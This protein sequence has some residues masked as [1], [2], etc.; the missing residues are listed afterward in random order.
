VDRQQAARTAIITTAGVVGTAVGAAGLLAAQVGHAKR[1][2][3]VRHTSPPYSDARYGSSKGSSIRLV[4]I[5]D[6]VA[7]SLGAEDPRDTI[8]A[9]LATLVSEYDGR[10]VV[11]STV[12]EVGARSRDLDAQID[13]AL[14]YRPHVAVVIIGGNDI[15]HLTPQWQAIKSLDA[16]IRRLRSQ[17][18]QVVVGTVPDLGI[19][20]PFPLPLRWV[21]RQLGRS[22]A[23][24]QTVCVVQAG[25][26]AVSMGDTLGPEFDARPEDMFANDRF[27]PSAEGYEAVAQVIA[28]S[29]IAGLSRGE[30][31]EVLPDIFQSPAWAPLRQIAARAAELPGMEITSESVVDKPGTSWARWARMG[32]RT[33]PPKTLNTETGEHILTAET[34]YPG[35]EWPPSPTPG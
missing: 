14:H 19:V 21:A 12:A 10:G 30:S 2:I 25:G 34:R 22:L 7:T 8:G 17:D 6:S 1:S 26:R 32:R 16:A 9:R 33:L 24:A 28:P 18:V 23:A 31:G 3:G 27:H 13:I 11:L 5:G 35:T 29:V 4:M 20:R 15:T